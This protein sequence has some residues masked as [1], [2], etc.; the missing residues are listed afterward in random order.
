VNVEEVVAATPRA[1]VEEN[2][3]RKL[4]EGVRKVGNGGIVVAADTVLEAGGHILGKPADEAQAVHYLET[5]S[6][7]SATAY[8]AVAVAEAGAAE[9]CLATETAEVH[10][11]VLSPDVIRWYLSTGEPM[12]RAGA[13]GI[14]QIGE[15]LTESVEGG[16]SC[17]SGLPKAALLL[18]L[19]RV[20]TDVRKETKE[21]KGSVLGFKHNC[22]VTEFRGLTPLSLGGT[23]VQL[24]ALT[25]AV[26]HEVDHRHGD[27]REQR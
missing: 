8:S 13:F 18:A 11:K 21:T 26:G 6:G 12:G 22:C 5:L 19:A 2:A 20:A 10:F 23:R 24:K 16:Y 3:T 15:V 27:Q 14:G 7:A 4:V 25:L 9:G 1:T 17:V